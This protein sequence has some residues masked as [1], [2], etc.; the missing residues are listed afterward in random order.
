MIV[1]GVELTKLESLLLSFGD[2]LDTDE[3]RDIAALR[4]LQAGRHILSRHRLQRQIDALEA[5]AAEAVHALARVNR[6]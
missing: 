2:V 3:L 5:A 6:P 1:N 4:R